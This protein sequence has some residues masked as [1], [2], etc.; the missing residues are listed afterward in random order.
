MKTNTG[1]QINPISPSVIPAA[2]NGKAAAIDVLAVIGG[3]LFIKA[4]CDSMT[5]TIAP[6]TVIGIKPYC[7]EPV[8]DGVY[9][10]E[11]GGKP[12]LRRIQGLF[13]GGYCLLCDNPAYPS[14]TV[15]TLPRLLAEVKA[16]VKPITAQIN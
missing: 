3:L 10:V 12:A 11:I 2:L 5:P 1:N 6:E 13:A 9:L 4:P 8:T 14:P 16:V 7:N 15:Q